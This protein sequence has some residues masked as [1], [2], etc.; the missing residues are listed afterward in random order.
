MKE[1]VEEGGERG[2]HGYGSGW[3]GRVGWGRGGGG[4]WFVVLL[5]ALYCL[6]NAM[7]LSTNGGSVGAKWSQKRGT[8]FGEFD[9]P[10]RRRA[11]LRYEFLHSRPPTKLL[12][13]RW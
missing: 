11:D 1:G 7:R 2:G 5:A 9:V 6:L 10:P 13:T 8:G 4:D 3:G 12:H